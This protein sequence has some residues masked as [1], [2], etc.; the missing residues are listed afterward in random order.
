MIFAESLINFFKK[1]KINF[2]V[3]VPDSVLKNFIKKLDMQKN[4]THLTAANEGTAV[5]AAI[6]YH[7]STGKLPCVY[8]QNSGLGNAI[9]PLISIAH[10]KVYSIPM[11]LVI[12][13][14]GAPNQQDEPQHEAKGEITP[15]LLKL[16]DIE[17]LL[18]D[19]ERDLKKVDTKIYNLKKKNKILALLI[20]N[21]TLII[22]NKQK[23]KTK[24]K[25][26]LLAR[27]VFIENLL[28]N[29]NKNTKIIS[30]T[31]YTSRELMQ[32]RKQSNCK[33]GRDFYMVG[34][35]GHASSVALG[36]SLYNKDVICLDG[37]GSTLMHLGAMA[38]NGFYG[39][40]NFKHIMLNNNSH[41]SVGGFET[42]TNKI[43]FQKLTQ[44]LNYKNYFKIKNNTGHIKIIKKFLKSIGPSFLEVVIRE[45]AL[46]NLE[47]PKRLK[48][49]KK[50]FML[51]V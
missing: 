5:S 42:G 26:K 36:E 45:G 33:N 50:R 48:D 11:I 14:R 18:I 8:M 15:K 13:W 21:K 4:I 9:N 23:P 39:K 25:N 19:H 17:Y 35:M 46:K 29:V 40:K 16:L 32:I 12:G 51:K 31:G 1:K 6:G 41:E 27:S 43:N 38:T 20:K 7:L 37:D 34:G 2:Y 22:K 47:R 24:I 28:K 30:T 10:K 3:G 49:I 44:S